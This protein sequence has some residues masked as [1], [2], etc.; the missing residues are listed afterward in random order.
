MGKLL[1]AAFYRLRKNKVFW[2]EIGMTA[3]LSAYIVL[4]NY[5]T[6]I[7]A[8]ENRLYLDNV[9]FVMYQLMSLLLAASISLI[10]G[11][12][13]SDGTIRNK[14]IVGHTRSQVYFS[15]LIASA[16][17]SVLVVLVHGIITYGL[18]RL[19]FGAFQMPIGQVFTGIVSALL[20]S[21][22]FAAMFVAIA[23][24]CSS[25]AVTA[26]ASMLLAI[27]LLYLTS[28]F[29]RAL[30]EP[31]MV[32]DGIRISAEGVQFGE[33]IPNPAYVSGIQRTVYEWIYDLLPN[34]QL[35]QIF[36]LDFTR[37]VRWPWLS[38]SLTVMIT[39]L[40]YALFRKKDIK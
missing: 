3:I 36:D 1:C 31:E 12:E 40:G 22:V 8:S 6:H 13:Y 33:L 27:G 20:T 35:Q 38:I 4:A 7:Q 34:G 32:Y 15:N 5:S 29:A 11:T 18:G 26:V 14:L 9:F 21:F 25:K 39:I 16:V 17:P 19:L 2:T 10:V 28:F 23:M 24:N 30:T 37:C